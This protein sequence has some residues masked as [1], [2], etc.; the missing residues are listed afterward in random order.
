MTHKAFAW[1]GYAALKVGMRL[2][3]IA[4]I[5]RFS[6]Q[7]QIIDLLEELQIDHV[8]DVGANDGMFAKH[9]RM[10]G[11]RGNIFCFEPIT[12]HCDS[13]RKL[14]RG[15][16]RWQVFD[17]ALGDENGVK[18]FNIFSTATVLSSFLSPVGK[19]GVPTRIESITIRRM[20][21]VLD[22]LIQNGAMARIFLKI[23]TQ[24]YDVEVL[25]GC[26]RWVDKISILQSEVSVRP[27]YRHMTHYTEALGYYESLGFSLLNLY[28]VNRGKDG[29][30]Y[31]Y[32]C[33][34]ARLDRF[35][36]KF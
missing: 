33:V 5:T 10:S 24:G 25:K 14:A 23:D 19:Q 32:D 3:E 26:G 36:G 17:F 16:P 21:E 18:P 27:I 31:E 13:I 29:G 11:Y 6:E 1:M 34:M 4:P 12:A 8:L 28:V 20:D 22:E 15:D 9:L 2:P 35:E 30:I 7:G